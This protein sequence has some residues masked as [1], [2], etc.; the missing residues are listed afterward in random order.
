MMRRG[1]L[2]PAAAARLLIAAG[3][4]DLMVVYLATGMLAPVLK[5][6][7]PLL[8]TDYSVFAVF[9]GLMLM[10]WLICDLLLAGYS[11]GRLAV[12]LEMANGAGRHLPLPRRAVRL[13]GK[14]TTL[15]LTGLRLDRL[16]GYD[17]AAG[18]VWLSAMSPVSA[19]PV[20]EWRLRFL[21]GPHARRSI[22]LAKIP[23]FTTSRT[24][25]IGRDRNWA[26]L[27]LNDPQIS[28]QHCI[29]RIRDQRLELRDG[30]DDGRPSANGTH[31]GGRKIS[32]QVWTGL[33][34]E[35]GFQVGTVRIVLA[36]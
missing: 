18:T 4:L 13:V 19:V 12:G 25:R 7:I 21:T 31:V 22:P 8:D 35:R 1:A 36:T 30:G 5:R 6:E 34:P 11:P 16:A 2:E 3:L 27:P 20:E 14:M 24:I 9:G 17:R 23:G 15:G 33:D 10:M 26:N 28:G 32:S 29:L